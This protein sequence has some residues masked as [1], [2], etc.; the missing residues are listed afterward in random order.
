M[1]CMLKARSIEDFYINFKYIVKLFWKY[2]P[3]DTACADFKSSNLIAKL[4]RRNEK[5]FTLFHP[6]HGYDI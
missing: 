4:F 1:P 6:I 5:I 3:Y 2:L